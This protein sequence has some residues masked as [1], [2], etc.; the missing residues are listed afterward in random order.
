MMMFFACENG[1]YDRIKLSFEN[2]CRFQI[3]VAF[4]NDNK[5]LRYMKFKMEF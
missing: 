4:A 3:I 5:K 1:K 2:Q